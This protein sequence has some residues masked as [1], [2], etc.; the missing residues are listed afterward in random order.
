MDHL[1]E[2]IGLRGYGQRDPL[3]EYKKEAFDL[4]QEMVERAEGPRVERLFKTRVVQEERGAPARTALLGAGRLAGRPR[5]VRPAGARLSDARAGPSRGPR[6]A[7]RSAAT[8]PAPAGPA[9][10]T[11]SAAS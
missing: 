2:G 6:T 5:R 4:F 1:K 9:R 10:S 3:T 7:R 11:R 8:I